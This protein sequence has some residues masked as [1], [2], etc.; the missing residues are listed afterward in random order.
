MI[1]SQCVMK[2]EEDADLKQCSL[3]S[4]AIILRRSGGGCDGLSPLF[5]SPLPP[6]QQPF[7]PIPSFLSTLFSISI[8]TKVPVGLSTGMSIPAS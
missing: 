6:L 7:H 2:I 1:Q 3:H 8:I 4:L 5:L